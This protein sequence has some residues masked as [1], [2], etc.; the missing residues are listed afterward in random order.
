[1][2]TT[3]GLAL[4]STREQLQHVTAQLS[5]TPLSESS[6]PAPEKFS[7]ESSNCGGFL[8]Q[9]NLVFNRSPRTFSTEQSKISFVLRLLTGRALR[10]AEARFSDCQ[11]F[12][13]TFIEFVT[14]FKTVFSAELDPVQL[15]HSLLSLKQRLSPWSFVLSPLGV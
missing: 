9:I 2:L 12:G 6:S 4:N 5:Q 1:M 8:F 14:E 7:G 15:S 13:C 3:K 11:A 10:W